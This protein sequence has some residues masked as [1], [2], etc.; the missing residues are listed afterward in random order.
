M[1]VLYL[2]R[3]FPALTETF[4]AAEV[5]G[6]HH[7]GI[8]VSVASLGTRPDAKLVECNP[9]I[10]VHQVPRRP[11]E[12]RFQRA[13]TG[14]AWLQTVQ[15]R[16]DAARLPW[17]R[18]LASGFDR[19][20]V[21]FAGE[22]AEMA[23]ALHLD[24]GIPFSVTVH[25]ADL[26]KPRPT[27]HTVL[28]AA[29]SVLTISKHNQATLGGLGLRATLVRCG[30]DL[31]QLQNQPSPGG[32]FRALFVGRDVPKKGLE[33]L[34]EAW[35]GLDRPEA[36]LVL[37]TE[38]QRRAPPTNVINPGLVP[39]S[40]VYDWM[41]RS[42]VIVLPVRRAEDGDMDGV[43]LVLME[44]LALGRP[45]I[46]CPVSGIPELID[47]AVGWLVPSE[48]PKAL[49]A[50]LRAAADDPEGRV[51]RGQR[52]QQRLIERD[53]HLRSQVAGVID[54]WTGNGRSTSS[55]ADDGGPVE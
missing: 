31:T 1:N 11:W 37:L 54:A 20:H 55:L 6:V 23:Y 25:A 3:Y 7:A 46:T 33:T 42:H 15:R 21:H 29:D 26:F 53:Y 40:Q 49:R 19:I 39:P 22:A 14:E 9:E 2:M 24:L 51:R 10:E 52:G 27:L 35:D 38:T 28:A 4:V 48:D 47:S 34:L 50:A 45:V 32:A 41:T 17:L 12:G 43:P 16:K 8:S 18:K 30:P 36:E 44:A 5:L 13:S